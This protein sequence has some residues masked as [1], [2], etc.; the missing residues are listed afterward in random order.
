MTYPIKLT[1]FLMS[2]L[3]KGTASSDRKAASQSSVF[4]RL[5][6]NDNAASSKPNGSRFVYILSTV[7]IHTYVVTYL[8]TFFSVEG[9]M[10]IQMSMD[11]F[12]LVARQVP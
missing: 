8:F 12:D 2:R 10:Q 6:T 7:C 11:R 1:I 4:D 5:S 9:L 3:Q